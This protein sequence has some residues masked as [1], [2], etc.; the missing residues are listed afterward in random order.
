[1]LN[2][3]LSVKKL[4]RI[5]IDFIRRLLVV[6]NSLKKIYRVGGC[7]TFT[8]AKINYGQVLKEKKILVTG[9]STG[10]GLAIAK[11]FIQEGALVII[12]G[13][14]EDKL[15]AASLEINSDNLKTIVWD[16]ADISIITSKIDECIALLDGDIDILI[17]NAGILNTVQFPDVLEANWDDIYKINHKGLFFLS[18]SITKKWLSGNSYKIKKIINISSQGG[19]V[20]ATYPYRMTKWDVAGLTQGLGLKLAPHGIIVNGIAP[21]IV[22]T[23]MQRGTL[24]QGENN[25]CQ[26]NPL[27]RFAIPEEI[28]ELALFMASDASNFIVGQ[29]ILCDGGFSLK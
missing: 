26:H 7:S 27:G 5:S 10:I 17:N 18:Q 25:F 8:I 9:G 6:F 24:L 4:V 13:R 3:R 21:G 12:T 29:T 28:A 1:M 23:A 20:G 15:K 16:V 2:G 14:N 19:F 11:K 22:A